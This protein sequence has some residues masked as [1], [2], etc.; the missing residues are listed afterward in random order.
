MPPT[1]SLRSTTWNS[2][3]TPPTAHNIEAGQGA[4]RVVGAVGFEPTTFRP[5]AERIV[6]SMRPGACPASP[7]SPAVDILDAS[8][9]AVGTKAVPP[10]RGAAG[11]LERRGPRGADQERDPDMRDL[12]GEPRYIALTAA[13]ARPHIQPGTGDYVFRVDLKGSRS[14]T[15]SLL[16]S[17]VLTVSAPTLIDP[18]TLGVLYLGDAS[19]VVDPPVD[20]PGPGQG[21][22]GGDGPC[23]QHDPGRVSEPPGPHCPGPGHRRR[24]VRLQ[25]DSRGRDTRA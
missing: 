15:G 22:A 1:S 4:L 5:P 11:G 18:A 24:R 8:D 17:E 12:G 2:A 9:V 10:C 23:P 13:G 21:A 20:E 16:V 25:A 3:P 14:P 7:S 19:V 6:V